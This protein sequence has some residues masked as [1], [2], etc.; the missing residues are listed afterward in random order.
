[1]DIYLSA[2]VCVKSEENSSIFS[3][4]QAKLLASLTL[5]EQELSRQKLADFSLAQPINKLSIY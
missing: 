1:M 3:G 5:N 4:L 2:N